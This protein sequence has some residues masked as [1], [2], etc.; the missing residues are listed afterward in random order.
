MWKNNPERKTLPDSGKSLLRA[1][2]FAANELEIFD[3]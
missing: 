3:F 1:V 2:I